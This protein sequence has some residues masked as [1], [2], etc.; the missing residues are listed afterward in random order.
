MRIQQFKNN[1]TGFGANWSKYL[2][3]QF[4]AL[5]ASIQKSQ[6][7]HEISLFRAKKRLIDNSFPKGTIYSTVTLDNGV[8]KNSYYL[9]VADNAIHITSVP[10]SATKVL[11]MFVLNRIA[12]KLAKMA[13]SR[14]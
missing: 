3:N 6:D 14:G 12:T 10:Q 11:N 1:N 7:F 9:K 2:Q 5:D 4:D 13:K 8:M